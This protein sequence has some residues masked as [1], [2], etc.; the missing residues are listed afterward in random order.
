MIRC[1][2]PILLFLA[3]FSPP[4]V[5]HAQ[6]SAPGPLTGEDR[7]RALAA[8]FA[9]VLHQ[10]LTPEVAT[11]RFDYIT[12]F[13]FDGDWIGNNN[14]AH[15]EDARY[16][17]Q[18]YLYYA[19]VETET[20]YFITYAAFHPRDWSLEQD[21]YGLVLDRVKEK[22][23]VY[24]PNQAREQAEFN[25]ENDLEGLMVVVRKGEEPGEAR[26]EAV[27]TLAH[28]HFY[29]YLVSGSSL[30]A[31]GK[32]AETIAVDGEHSIVYVESQKHGIKR[33][34]EQDRQ[35]GP[36]IIY[37]DGGRAEEPKAFE[38][39]TVYAPAQQEA[40]Y[41]LLPIYDTFW[42]RAL[43]AQEPNYTFGELYDFGALTTEATS[44]AGN[45]TRRVEF[46]LGRIGVAL[47]G[48]VA[49]K[50]KARM[51]WGWSDTADQNLAMGDWFLD[52]AK[53]LAAHFPAARDISHRYVSN[54]FAGIYREEAH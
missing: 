19:V 34:E 18:A 29:K 52:P 41:D 8:R 16:P 10:R 35:G 6:Q 53:T 51:P 17:L 45:R 49:G 26:L 9:P 27:E 22:V 36:V 13:D 38:G 40:S 24:F 30:A 21:L 50:N 54:P 20:H 28:N 48:D 43:A 7:E 15:A 37:R 14:W 12:R 11:H 31:A 33:Y 42:L 47:R 23:G 4:L 1:L 32:T 2:L 25:H 44:L 46:A 3:S 39:T 5:S